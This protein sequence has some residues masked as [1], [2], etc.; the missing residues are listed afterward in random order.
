MSISTDAAGTRECLGDGLAVCRL[1]A[2]AR[3][4]DDRGD[5]R[6]VLL[7]VVLGKIGADHEHFFRVQRRK[8]GTARGDPPGAGHHGERVPRLAGAESVEMSRT[9]MGHH[10]RGWHHHHP[11]V[12][13]KIEAVTLQPEPQQHR[14]RRPL[15][16]GAERE[17]TRAL[18]NEIAQRPAVAHARTPEPLRERDG[19]AVQIQHDARHALGAGSAYARGGGEEHSRRRMGR[20]EFAVDHLFTDRRPAEFAREFH[21]EPVPFKEPEFPGHDDR[22]AVGEAGEADADGLM[23]APAFSIQSRRCWRIFCDGGAV[24]CPRAKATV[25][26]SEMPCSFFI[27]CMNFIHLCLSHSTADSSVPSASSPARAVLRRP[28][29]SYISRNRP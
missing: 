13:F 15:I 29:A 28:H 21:G 26:A 12:V 8:L 4:L 16:H 7:I 6:G 11:R 14:V 24:S 1:V 5:D 2:E 3:G 20:V 27:A 25:R 17:R 10:L 23:A 18:A 9:Q 22:H 19:V